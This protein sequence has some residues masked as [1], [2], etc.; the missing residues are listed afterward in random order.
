MKYLSPIAHRLDSAA[1]QG[2]SREQSISDLSHYRRV[3]FRGPDIVSWLQTVHEIEVPGVNQAALSANGLL[4]LRLSQTEFMFL[5]RNND[6]S[7]AFDKF[8]GNAHAMPIS[9]A[10]PAIY[11]LPRQDSHACFMIKG[12]ACSDLFSRLCA[13][14]LRVEKFENGQVAQTSMA[15]TSV[16]IVRHDEGKVP[17]YL[18]LVDSAVAEYLWDCLLEAGQAY[19]LPGE[20]K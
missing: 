4:T 5:E 9:E 17:A 8:M 16:I 19:D 18:V 15:R 2:G 6:S 3:G 20:N 1:E 14:D 10:Q 7:S 12:A 13:V 11:H